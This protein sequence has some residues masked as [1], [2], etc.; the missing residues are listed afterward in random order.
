M[1]NLEEF[2]SRLAAVEFQCPL[3]ITFLFR[4]MHCHNKQTIM[5]KALSFLM[6]ACQ[7]GHTSFSLC[8]YVLYVCMSIFYCKQA[9]K[10]TEC[11]S[12]F[13]QTAGISDISGFA[14]DCISGQTGWQSRITWMHVL[15]SKT[16]RSKVRLVCIRK[17]QF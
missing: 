1:F 17:N 5:S 4:L 2:L 8:L 9:L 16:R 10:Y 12:F 14:A 6:A 11:W 15:A 7:D 3:K 13:A